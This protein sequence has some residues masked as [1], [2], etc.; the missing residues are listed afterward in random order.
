MELKNI[1]ECIVEHY[2][3]SNLSAYTS[4]KKN[5]NE[6]KKSNSN[7]NNESDNNISVS[8]CFAFPSYYDSKTISKYKLLCKIYKMNIEFYLP[9]Y[10][11]PCITY[12]YNHFYNVNKTE[13][14]DEYA[15]FIDI[16]YVTTQTTVCHF[17]NV[18]LYHTFS[19]FFLFYL[20]YFIYRENWK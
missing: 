20:F 18:F 9:E 17:R 5:N 8:C 19:S 4:K 2:N 16:G 15:L 1:K 14:Y 10:I 7:N 6:D 12:A 3:H 11:C 13:L